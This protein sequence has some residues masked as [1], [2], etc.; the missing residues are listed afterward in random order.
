MV[1]EVE[2]DE[3]DEDDDDVVDFVT[4]PSRGTCWS[5]TDAGRCCGV[6]AGETLSRL[7]CT[8]SGLVLWL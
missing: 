5:V 6:E 2:H 7:S 1:L 8:P 4:T 3:D